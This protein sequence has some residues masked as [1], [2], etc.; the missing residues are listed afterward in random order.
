VPSSDISSPADVP[1][2]VIDFV[3]AASTV[4]LSQLATTS[5]RSGRR[6]TIIGENQLE[7]LTV[8]VQ[9]ERERFL[10]SFLLALRVAVGGCWSARWHYAHGCQRRLVLDLLTSGGPPGIDRPLRNRRGSPGPLPQL[11]SL[12]RRQQ[13]IQ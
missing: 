1:A 10:H 8:E 2:T 6:L 3:V 5:K 11:A 12:H 9:E 13:F 7:L 4:S